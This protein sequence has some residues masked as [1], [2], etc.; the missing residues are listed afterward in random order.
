MWNHTQ[1][2]AE[3]EKTKAITRRAPSASAVRQT[4]LDSAD[5]IQKSRVTR[6]A[7][8][9]AGHA[10]CVLHLGGRVVELEVTAYGSGHCQFAPGLSDYQKTVMTMG[11][12]AAT[13]RRGERLKDLVFGGEDYGRS[14]SD[15]AL[16]VRALRRA[17]NDYRVQQIGLPEGTDMGECDMPDAWLVERYEP[18]F[19]F[20][21]SIIE[22]HWGFLSEL[23]DHL[24]A[25]G[26]LEHWEIVRQW[27]CY[28]GYKA[29][30]KPIE[31]Y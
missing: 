4:S 11:G 16:I 22:E 7:L 17:R 21:F 28:Q 24:A 25:E 14:A 30:G 27:L 18:V 31:S 9:E 8:H 6:A 1:V 23:S 5:A 29:G 3:L 26:R 12:F 15:V 20:S 13:C 2:L 19:D 10:V